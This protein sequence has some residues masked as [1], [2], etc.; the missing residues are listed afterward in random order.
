[1]YGGEGRKKITML[2]GFRNR[3]HPLRSTESKMTKKNNSAS[4]FHIE[5]CKGWPGSNMVSVA[6]LARTFPPIICLYNTWLCFG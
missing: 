4:E 3:P 2:N 5:K 1:M 6:T